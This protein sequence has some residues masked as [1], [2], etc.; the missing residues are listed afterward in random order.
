M[1]ITVFYSCLDTIE[2]PLLVGVG[3]TGAKIQILKWYISGHPHFFPNPLWNRE[4]KTKT[5]KNQ[6]S[7]IAA[8]FSEKV[9]L[10]HNCCL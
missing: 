6:N 1:S 4:M 2:Q 5:K 3:Y 9:P 10:I 7:E 8:H